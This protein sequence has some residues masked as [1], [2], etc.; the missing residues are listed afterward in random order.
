[1]MQSASSLGVEDV[2]LVLF[3]ALLLL[4]SDDSRIRDDSFLFLL[5]PLFLLHT[6]VAFI[7]R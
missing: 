4:I 1:M 7:W 2:A 3:S 6:D 5:L